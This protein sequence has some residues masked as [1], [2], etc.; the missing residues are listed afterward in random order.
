MAL[1]GDPLLFAARPLFGS[2]P[3]MKKVQDAD[4]RDFPRLLRA[5]R[6]RPCR[7]RAAACGQ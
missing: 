1:L 2:N 5:R 7:H 4:A 6:E 3:P